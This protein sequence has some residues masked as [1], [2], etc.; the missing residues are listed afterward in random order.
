M[1]RLQILLLA[2]FIP[3]AAGSAPVAAAAGVE[4]AAGADPAN[5][6]ELVA[7][8]EKTY[9]GVSTL[10]ADF[11]QVN[12]SKST[13]AETRQ[14]GHVSLKR[15]H[16]M[17]W[18]FV[19]ADSNTFVTDGATMWVWSPA[20]NQV[21]V[22]SA[23]GASG[24]GMTQLLDDLSQ[25]N[26]LFDVTLVGG[27]GAAPSYVVDLKP[28]QQANFK[29]LRL[30]L[31]KKKYTVE[32]VLMTDLFDNQVELSFTGVKMNQDL[33]DAQFSFQIPAG[34]QVISADGQ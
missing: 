7:A 33:P 5:A 22:S 23:S 32:Q 10:K 11:V 21:I 34:A 16:K 18:D 13:G 27:V 12:R 15:P 26:T 24:G 1:R 19:G 3:L 14:K 17:R 20:T 8:V 6:A 30:T 31:T 28:K 2:C 9:G 4:A 29:N 25:L